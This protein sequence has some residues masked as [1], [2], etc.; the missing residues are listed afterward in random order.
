MWLKQSHFPAGTM[1]KWPLLSC[2][3]LC[4]VLLQVIT[5]LMCLSWACTTVPIVL[6]SPVS[7]LI[8]SVQVE[9][10]YMFFFPV[11]SFYQSAIMSTSRVMTG[12][13]W[14]SLEFTFISCMRTQFSR[15]IG[16][17]TSFFSPPPSMNKVDL[18]SEAH[19]GI[20]SLDP[21]SM[22]KRHFS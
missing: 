21:F 17:I 19:W 4:I 1:R 7:G 12:N 16:V 3:N 10:N 11:N 20:Y 9:T 13:G 18:S 22:N 8:G 5:A 2:G 15:S 14:S 6:L